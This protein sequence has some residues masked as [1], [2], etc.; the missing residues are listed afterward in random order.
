MDPDSDTTA[1]VSTCRAVHLSG[2]PRAIRISANA[3]ALGPGISYVTSDSTQPD[4]WLPPLSSLPMAAT[5]RQHARTALVCSDKA[6][7]IPVV[8]CQAAEGSP[9]RHDSLDAGDER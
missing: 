5:P 1:R 7:L 9:V 2:A 8:G 4:G 6:V 3:Y